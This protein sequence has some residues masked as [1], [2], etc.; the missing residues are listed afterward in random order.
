MQ[1]VNSS[2]VVLVLETSFKF[3]QGL[4]TESPSQNLVFDVR[5]GQE[6]YRSL[7]LIDI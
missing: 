1:F 5:K 2:V 3:K 6:H 7:T 4:M